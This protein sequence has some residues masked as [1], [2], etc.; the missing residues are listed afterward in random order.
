MVGDGGRKSVPGGGLKEGDIPRP[1][2]SLNLYV[3]GSLVGKINGNFFG[4]FRIEQM[5]AC[6]DGAT[7]RRET[8]PSSSTVI[9][10]FCIF[11]DNSNY[12]RVRRGRLRTKVG[13][14]RRIRPVWGER[15]CGNNRR[16]T[17]KG[18]WA[19]SAGAHGGI[20]DQGRE[21]ESQEQEELFHV[22]LS[23]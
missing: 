20:R 16:E 9:L 19:V 7:V 17:M 3:E 8:N 22:F 2:N 21:G 23:G 10:R 13:Q 5:C 15:A 6:Q 11:N 12:C 1:V 18:R 4:R 14:R